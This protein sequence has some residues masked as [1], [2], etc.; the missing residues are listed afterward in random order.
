VSVAQ[1]QHSSE[2]GQQKIYEADI[3]GLPQ[4]CES[5]T[6]RHG[7][8]NYESNCRADHLTMTGVLVALSC[9]QYGIE[10]EERHPYVPHWKQTIGR[11]T[12]SHIVAGRKM[13]LLNRCSVAPG[14]RNVVMFEEKVE[15]LYNVKR[16][17]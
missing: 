14:R 6:Y 9:C 16:G 5:S 1:Q 7:H 4:K 10:V 2:A 15:D 3:S 8:R 17:V 11:G 13:L 12:Q